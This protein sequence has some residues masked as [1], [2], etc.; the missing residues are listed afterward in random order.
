MSHSEKSNSLALS[1]ITKN[2]NPLVIPCG[3]AAH[4]IHMIKYLKYKHECKNKM[5]F[6]GACNNQAAYLEM[7][8]FIIC[9]HGKKNKINHIPDNILLKISSLT[10]AYNKYDF[11]TYTGG[12]ACLKNTHMLFEHIP[13]AYK[14]WIMRLLPQS[15]HCPFCHDNI[16]T[17]ADSGSA[18]LSPMPACQTRET[19]TMQICVII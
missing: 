14:F 7:F 17:A 11:L 10:P 6:R 2:R 15:N 19:A 12:C 3:R 4:I 13:F 16:N 1:C 8:C 18:A 5:R 9:L